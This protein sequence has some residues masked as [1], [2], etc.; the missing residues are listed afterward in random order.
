MAEVMKK[1]KTVHG[2]ECKCRAD[3][4]LRRPS[5]W[6]LKFKGFLWKILVLSYHSMILPVITLSTIVK[7]QKCLGKMR[8]L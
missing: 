5:G 3:S 7:G 2:A 6:E 1:A 4:N 8:I